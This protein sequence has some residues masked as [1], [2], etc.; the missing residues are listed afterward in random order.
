MEGDIFNMLNSKSDI[1]YIGG[2]QLMKK[3]ARDQQAK[4][5]EKGVKDRNLCSSA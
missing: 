4:A 3:D 5:A 2:K 1:C